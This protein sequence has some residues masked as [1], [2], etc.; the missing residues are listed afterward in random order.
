MNHWQLLTDQSYSS[1][2]SAKLEGRTAFLLLGSERSPL[3]LREALRGMKA[4]WQL[5][6]MAGQTEGADCVWAAEMGSGGTPAAT[7]MAGEGSSAT[8]VFADDEQLQL[9]EQFAGSQAWMAK[10]PECRFVGS[11]GDSW[12]APMA[13][14]PWSGVLKVKG[15][16]R[17]VSST[18]LSDHPEPMMMIE[19]A[20]WLCR[21]A[22]E[23]GME[24]YTPSD[25][26][27]A[28]ADTSERA[29]LVA[30]MQPSL[31]HQLQIEDL[32]NPAAG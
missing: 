15:G 6:M 22:R 13:L 29:R 26:Q 9:L 28:C 25:L 12:E 3:L 14:A 18:A 11:S 19:V 24:L 17:L 2:P 7:L 20:D 1:L 27:K 10:L 23:A 16:P 5:P 30:V 4:P 8:M 21:K 31:S 32:Q